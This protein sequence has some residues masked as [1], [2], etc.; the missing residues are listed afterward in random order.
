MRLWQ[1]QAISIMIIVW[2]AFVGLADLSLGDVP[3]EDQMIAIAVEAY[4]DKLYPVA[5]SQILAFLERYP[6]SPQKLH[7]IYLL[8]RTYFLQGEFP[9]ARE[10]FLTLINDDDVDLEDQA[11][12]LFWLADSFAQLDRW[13]EAKA[14]YIEFI[15]KTVATITKWP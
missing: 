9:E 6:K 15:G 3:S 2:G 13:E 11:T 8:G 12:G 5:E 4:S 1:R 7:M 10:T 14:Y